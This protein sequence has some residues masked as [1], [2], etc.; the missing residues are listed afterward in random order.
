MNNHFDGYRQIVYKIHTIQRPARHFL[1]YTDT[2]C[3][4]Q[5]SYNF[6]LAHRSTPPSPNPATC[7]H[8]TQLSPFAQSTF[9]AHCT[10]ITHSVPPPVRVPQP[11]PTSPNYP[12][13]PNPRSWPSV[14]PSPTLFSPRALQP[15]PRSGLHQPS[16]ASLSSSS[17]AT[18]QKTT[19]RQHSRLPPA[20]LPPPCLPPVSRVHHQ[21][22]MD[23][24]THRQQAQ[25]H[26]I[27][28]RAEQ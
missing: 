21:C 20:T 9:F 17:T 25:H 28:G 11:A 18:S 15:P 22:S 5:K 24:E 19:R 1:P 3:L 16:S 13:S 23:R 26:R 14:H 6:A 10:P 12:H 4:P 2:R 27:P 8:F 7:A